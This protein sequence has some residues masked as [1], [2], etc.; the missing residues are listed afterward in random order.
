MKKI[1]LPAA[2]VA[3]AIYWLFFRKSTPSKAA[4]GAS[5]DPLPFGLPGSPTAL[6]GF[7]SPALGGFRGPDFGANSF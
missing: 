7:Q 5:L 6:P 2:V 1:L 4:I 3:A